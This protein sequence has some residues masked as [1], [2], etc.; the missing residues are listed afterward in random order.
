M[1]GIR[2][3]IL[4]SIS[5]RT[6]SKAWEKKDSANGVTWYFAAPFF[7]KYVRM[8]SVT[9]STTTSQYWP[10]GKSWGQEKSTIS[11]FKLEFAE[12]DVFDEKITL[13]PSRDTEEDAPKIKQK[14]ENK[15]K[16]MKRGNFDLVMGK[17]T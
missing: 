15:K 17:L 9:R 11:T 2:T 6:S 12:K 14:R 3:P 13:P 4:T 5:I 10:F 8:I 1:I 16:N 7:S